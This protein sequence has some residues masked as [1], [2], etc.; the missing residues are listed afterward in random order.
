MVQN[1]LQLYLADVPIAFSGVSAIR[2]FRI[3]ACLF[4]RGWELVY[5][6]GAGAVMDNS[7]GHEIDGY[8]QQQIIGGQHEGWEAG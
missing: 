4:W 7:E 3:A 5:Y 8:P 6:Q 1:I 2:I